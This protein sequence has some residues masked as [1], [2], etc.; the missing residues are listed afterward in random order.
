MTLETPVASKPTPAPPTT[1][2]FSI[3]PVA[4]ERSA[5]ERSLEFWMFIFVRLNSAWSLIWNAVAVA[6][7]TS[8]PSMKSL[9]PSYARAAAPETSAILMPFAWI[10]PLSKTANAEMHSPVNVSFSRSTTPFS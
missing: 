2:Q 5:I 9:P 6:A 8:P 1:L 3:V 4:S 10:V 7:V